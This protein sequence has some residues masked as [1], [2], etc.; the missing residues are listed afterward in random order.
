MCYLN[1]R[2]TK[3]W[4]KEE[5]NEWSSDRGMKEGCRWEQKLL[6]EDGARICSSES[7]ISCVSCSW[8]I[9][10][11]VAFRILSS[12][13]GDCVMTCMIKE[14]SILHEVFIFCTCFVQRNSWILKLMKLRA[15]VCSVACVHEYQFHYFGM[16]YLKSVVLDCI[17]VVQGCVVLV[18][19]IEWSHSWFIW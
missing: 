5:W 19:L 7:M 4:E 16:K 1:F 8:E 6:T 9:C 10:S 11:G 3:T 18:M 2:Q 17:F 14:W 15:L 13:V 12:Q